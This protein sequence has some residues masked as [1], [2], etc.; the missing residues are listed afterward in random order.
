MTSNPFYVY[1]LKDPRVSPAAIFYI[2]KGTG[3]RL[4]NHLDEKGGSEKN[5]IIAKIQESG[6]D[7]IIEKIVDDLTEPQALKIEAE[8]ISALGIRS[9]GGKLTNRVC[10]SG[11]SPKAGSKNV[12]EGCY[13]RAQ[14]GLRLIRQSVLEFIKANPK[15]L[16]NGDVAKYLGLQADYLGG[17]INY[18]SYSIL[19]LLLRENAIR[20]EG[21]MHIFN[22]DLKANKAV[23]RTL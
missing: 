6:Y 12:P 13:E 3:F 16:T 5:V 18:L 10:P 19:G 17:S 7:V 21:R 2:G 11:N 14:G 1:A 4:E 20:K 23:H 8:M 15:G 22:N 9:K